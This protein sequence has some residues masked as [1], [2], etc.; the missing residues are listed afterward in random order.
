MEK[1]RNT[2]FVIAYPNKWNDNE[3][4][5]LRNAM[6]KADLV[7]SWDAKTKV[8]FVPKREALQ[9]FMMRELKQAADPVCLSTFAFKVIRM[10]NFHSL[11]P[12]L[13]VIP[14]VST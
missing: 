6:I 1:A 7:G 3:R 10:T 12:S 9:S 2:D 5:L 14:T 8:H 13:F 11:V 4:E